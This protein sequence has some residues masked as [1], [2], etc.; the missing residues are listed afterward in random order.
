MGQMGNS[1]P[2]ATASQIDAV[3]SVN[4][5]A[6]QLGLCCTPAYSITSRLYLNFPLKYMLAYSSVETMSSY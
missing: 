6:D 3:Q 2:P 1:T 5:T 4:I